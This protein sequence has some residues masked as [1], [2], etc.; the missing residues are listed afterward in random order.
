[1]HQIGYYCGRF[2][3]GFWG[4]PQNALSNAA[5]VIAALLAFRLWQRHNGDKAQLALIL[6]TAAIGLGSF[7]F[8]TTPNRMTLLIDLVPIQIFGLSC[9][10]Y[11]GLRHFHARRKSVLLAVTA[12]FLVRQAWIMLMPPA[13]LGGGIT[14]IP[15]ILLLGLCGVYLRCHGERVGSWLMLACI[16]Y[17]GALL[18]RSYDLYLCNVFPLGLHWA[19]HLLTALTA[20]TVLYG[21][22]ACPSHMPE[23]D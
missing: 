20:G 19:W 5:F 11:L 12:F 21:L 1:M 6:M 7:I 22:V 10:C 13:A 9:F 14:H 17:A 2:N 3:D 16:P 15:T 18:V 8:H 4:E 23:A